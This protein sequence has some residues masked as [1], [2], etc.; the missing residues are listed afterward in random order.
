MQ[1]WLY[2]ILKN[3]TIVDNQ[4]YYAKNGL[5]QNQRLKEPITLN[6]RQHRQRTYAYNNEHE[7]WKF[8]NT[9]NREISELL[10]QNRKNALI[11]FNSQDYEHNSSDNFIDIHGVDCMNFT[12]TTSN[13]IGFINKGDYSLK[14][15]SRFGDEFLKFIIS[16]AEGFVEIEN[17]GG[18]N[19]NEGYK[20]LLIYLWKIKMKKAYRLG[21]PKSYISKVENLNK[22]RGAIDVVDFFTNKHSGI[23][24]CKYREHSYNN[25]V[26]KLISAAFQ[27][28]GNHEFLNDCNFIRNAFHT[29]TNGEKVNRK[30]LYG[31]KHFS[32]P[33]YSE[34]ND[35]IDLSKLILK[36][37]LSNFGDNNQNSAFFFDISMLFEYFIKKRIK[38]I[39]VTLDS[40]FENRFEISSG[41]E[42]QTRKLEPDIVFHKDDKTFL[43]DV[44][45]KSFDFRYGVKRE[46]LFQLHTYIGQYGNK[47]DL[48]ACGFIYP[49]MADK[50]N[51]KFS[52]NKKFFK[53]IINMFG[54]NVNF[55]VVF[56]KTPSRDSHSYYTEFEKNSILFQKTL[57]EI[58]DNERNTTNYGTQHFV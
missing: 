7:I 9:T 14:I 27:K 26:T 40:K 51:E 29:A 2:N 17:Y 35:V 13:V 30:E 3:N 21:L 33:F 45:Y 16:D 23:Y 42:K 5:F 43:F 11:L 6:Q 20:W 19:A 46:D 39:G 8:L 47:H 15:S 18:S 1:E 41:V 25:N 55:Y 49:L 12:L 37:D 58:I 36:D 56:L 38:R 10:E 28:I 53:N 48:K 44:K 52:G 22:V 34:Y 4:T 24:K 54:K 50:W 32:N 31:T 57:I